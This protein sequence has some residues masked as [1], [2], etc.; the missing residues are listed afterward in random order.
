MQSMI[1][2]ALKKVCS[3]M[4]VK[5]FSEPSTNRIA[6]SNWVGNGPQRQAQGNLRQQGS[7]QPTSSKARQERSFHPIPSQPF[8]H[9]SVPV[10]IPALV[11]SISVSTQ[12]RQCSHLPTPVAVSPAMRIEH[13]CMS[14]LC[15]I[16][17]LHL[18]P[19]EPRHELPSARKGGIPCSPTSTTRGRPPHQRTWLWV[20][21]LL[22]N[23]IP[24][25]CLELI[26]I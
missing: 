11:P 9:T 25:P 16:H 20:A 21:A 3:I 4:L 13:G 17:L 6:P 15:L 22:R 24:G 5:T 14:S 18:S 2:G 12:L 23:L 26:T 8:I 10:P 7:R 1:D 19:H